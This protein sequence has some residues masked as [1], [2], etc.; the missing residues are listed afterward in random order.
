[1]WASGCGHCRPR[2]MTWSGSPR[3][4]I[5]SVFRAALQRAVPRSD[6]AKCGRPALD[7]VP[8]FKVLLL[9]AMHGA[10]GRAG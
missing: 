7:H 1:M 10:V 8:M 3:W 6:G 9:Q 2:V 4:S 5:S